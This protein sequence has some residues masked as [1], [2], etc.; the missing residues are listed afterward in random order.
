WT[1][2][3][4]LLNLAGDLLLRAAVQAANSTGS[5]HVSSQEW[6]SR[7]LDF[8]AASEK[9]I[10]LF[11]AVLTLTPNAEDEHAARRALATIQHLKA[12]VAARAEDADGQPDC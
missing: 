1:K 8:R 6:P 12:Q 2:S 3:P 4:R 7:T 11:A 10:S 5:P 9:A